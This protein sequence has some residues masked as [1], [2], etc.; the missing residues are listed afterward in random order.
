[1]QTTIDQ[2]GR[3]VVPKELRDRLGITA[4]SRIEIR[5]DGS[6]LRLDLIASDILIE[7]GDHLLIGGDLPLTDDDVRELRLGNQR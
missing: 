3:L 7:V 2:A 1:M 4:G 5:E 6:G